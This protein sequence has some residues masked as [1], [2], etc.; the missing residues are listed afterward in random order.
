MRKLLSGLRYLYNELEK[1]KEQDKLLSRIQMESS[2]G[3]ERPFL[4]IDGPERIRMGPRS[5][6]GK[7]AWVSCYEKYGNQEFSP[8]ITIEADV[9]IGNYACITAVDEIV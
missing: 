4:N 6:I 1:N 7:N 2:W 9:R 3:I 8:T 5:S